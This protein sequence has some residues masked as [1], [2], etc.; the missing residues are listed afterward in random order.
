MRYPQSR[1]NKGLRSQLA[2]PTRALRQVFQAGALMLTTM[3]AAQ[4]TDIFAN[5]DSCYVDGIDEK[6]R[7]GS[8][9]V[10]ENPNKQDGRKIDIQYVILP[11][12][13]NAEPGKALLGIAGGPGQSAIESAGYFDKLLT[14]T[15]QFR[16]ILLIDQRGTGSSNILACDNMSPVD[17]LAIN[18]EAQDMVALTKE[19]MD[20][21]N[22]DITQYGSLNAVTD[23]EA[24]RKAIGY[25]QLDVYGISYGTRMAQL[26]MRQYPEATS[27][28]ILDG[29]VPMQQN[30]IYIGDAIARATEIMLS[31]CEQ[32]QACNQ[33]FPELRN[34]LNAVSDRLA[35]QPLQTQVNDPVAG[36]MTDLTLTRS[37]FLGAIRMA[38]YAPNTRSLLP[39][40]IS[41]AAEGNYQPILGLYALTTDGAGIAMGMHASVVCGEDIPFVDEKAAEVANRT[42]VGG[43]MLRG[44]TEICTIWQIPPVSPEFHQPIASNIPT[45]LLSGEMDPATP[46]SWAELA[47]V[48]LTNAEHI[49]SPYA[50]HGTAAQTCA[51]GLIATLVKDGSLE[52]LDTECMERDTSRSFYLNANTVE[53]LANASNEE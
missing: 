26:Y 7:C 1:E 37:K 24:V 35:E 23:F 28:V 19:C 13:K 52:N 4:A 29:V 53:P 42:F 21:Q 16:D 48:Q 6:V 47:K 9:S 10:P 44:L 15:R 46:P 5:T 41:Q 8:I 30:L 39:Y 17:A 51:H 11:A 20:A 34:D 50:G 14:K 40:A 12:I 32:N 25:E 43:E 33:A 3:A 31:D 2:L 22:A 45:L 18:D 27:T 36:E 38:L 49:V